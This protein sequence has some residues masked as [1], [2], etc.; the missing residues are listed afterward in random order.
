MNAFLF[1]PFLL[2]L[3]AHLHARS[4]ADY[5][6]LENHFQLEVSGEENVNPILHHHYSLKNTQLFKIDLKTQVIA[7]QEKVRTIFG[8]PLEI[9]INKM[10]STGVNVLLERGPREEELSSNIKSN[11][12]WYFQTKLS[13]LLGLNCG[14]QFNQFS[15]EENSQVSIGVSYQV[16]KKVHLSYGVTTPLPTQARANFH[17]LGAV[18]SL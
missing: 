11:L 6:I 7:S 18:I 3:T 2:L 9:R 12:N 5:S 14:L 16:S 1:T 4:V 8:I 15:L 13:P 10:T 17:F